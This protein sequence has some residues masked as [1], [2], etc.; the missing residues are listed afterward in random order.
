[1]QIEVGS[2]V[3]GK[4]KTITGFGAFIDI[5]GG[6][7]GLVHISEISEGYVNDVNEILTVGQE[8]K[9]KVVSVTPEGKVNL[10]MKKVS[11]GANGQ[12][13]K[14]NSDSKSGSQSRSGRPPQ[15]WQGPKKTNTGE[16]QSFEDMMAKF[17]QVSDEKK[18][19]L[20]RYDSKRGS[21]GYSR[22]GQNR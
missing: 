17:K 12:G 6:G 18:S 1:M 13:E 3:S 14:K 19:D 9:A 16:K 10:S 21:V 22:R 8:V 15:V 5:E 2:V 7:V 4:V 11:P 20:K